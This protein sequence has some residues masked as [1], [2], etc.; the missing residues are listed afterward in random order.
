[1]SLRWEEEGESGVFIVVCIRFLC[2]MA[3]SSG[4]VCAFVIVVGFR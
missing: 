1:M 4:G 3:S 2:T